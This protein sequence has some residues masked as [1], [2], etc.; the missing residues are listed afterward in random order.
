MEINRK[1]GKIMKVI[2]KMREGENLGWCKPLVNK[3][4]TV[5]V[6]NGTIIAIRKD[7]RDIPVSDSAVRELAK[8]VNPSYTQYSGWDDT[9][10]ALEAGWEELG[11]TGCPW[12]ASCDAV[13]E[14]VEEYNFIDEE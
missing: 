3:N 7:D 13:N 9:H 1:K 10:I 4:V 5:A 14:A 12:K 6:N 8:E 2:E 11:C